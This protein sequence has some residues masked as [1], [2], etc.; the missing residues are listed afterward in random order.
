V[1]AK[2][3]PVY[4]QNIDEWRQV[5]GEWDEKVKAF[6]IEKDT[7]RAMLQDTTLSEE[8]IARYQ[9]LADSTIQK[10]DFTNIFPYQGASWDT[11]RAVAD[12]FKVM[13]PNSRYLNKVKLLSNEFEIPAEEQETEVQPVEE[14]E[15]QI[16]PSE[17]GYFACEDINTEL[18]LRTGMQNFLSS[19]S[20]PEDTEIDSVVY[21]FKVSVRGIM[22][23]FSLQTEDVPENVRNSIERAFQRMTFEPVM[24]EGEA[25]PAECQITFPIGN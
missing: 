19:I 8:E 14:A 17:E 2:E 16:Q 21:E 5:T 1:V 6:Q 11:V 24:Y 18:N 15:G 12:T 20:L 22:E 9:S 13:F 3:E 10:P 25:V 4:E 7:A 23:G